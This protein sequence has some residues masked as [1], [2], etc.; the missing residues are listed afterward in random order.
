M[1]LITEIDSLLNRWGFG[2]RCWRRGECI[3]RYSPEWPVF[4]G[5]HWEDRIM[6]ESVTDRLHIKQG[7]SIGRRIFFHDDYVL[8]VYLKRH[9]YLPWYLRLLAILWPYR[10]WSPGLREWEKLRWAEQQGWPVARAVAAGQW[11][12]PGWSLQSFIAIE[13]LRD[14]LPLHE[15]IPAAA[16]ALSPEAFASWK[17]ALFAELARLVAMLHQNYI[18]H[19]DL[20]ICHFFIDESHIFNFENNMDNKVYFIDLHRLKRH[21]WTAIWWQVKDLA[22]FFFSCEIDEIASFDRRVFWLNYC[23]YMNIRNMRERIL[24]NLIMIKLNLYKRNERRR[25]KRTCVSLS[26]MSV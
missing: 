24:Y 21:R 9:Y 4:A 5:L 16:K 8:C 17:R 12:G 13:E 20:Y 26:V 23:K 2:W 6:S 25:R 18:F 22:Q 1:S 14:M 7:R 3:L 15:A 11:I 10:P 19:K